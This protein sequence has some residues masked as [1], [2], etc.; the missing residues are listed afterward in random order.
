MARGKKI[1]LMAPAGNWESM[2]AAIDAGCDS[3]YFGIEQ[4]NMRA[5]QTMNFTLD[6][7]EEIVALCSPHDVRTYITLNTII[8]DH[9]LSLMRRIVDRAL[10]AGITAIIASD[11]AVISYASKVGLEVHISTQTN[12]TN[13]ETVEFFSHFADTMVLS[14]ELSMKQMKDL[15]DAVKRDNITGPNG[16][17]VEIEVFAHGALCVAVSGKCYM[18]LH[19]QAS[20]ANRGACIQNCRRSYTVKDTDSGYEFEIDDQYIMSPKDLCT[21]DFLDQLISTGVKVLKIEGRGRAPEYVKTVIECYREAID[22]VEAGTYN[23]ELVEAWMDRLKTVYNRG[24]WGGYYL[25][26]K[27]GEFSGGPGSKATQKKVFI[28]KGRH[29]YPKPQIGEFNVLSHGVKVGD[30]LLITGPTTGVIETEITSMM[31]DDKDAQEAKKGH[32]VTF[33]ISEKIRPSDKIYKIL[34]AEEVND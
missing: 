17:L 12:I 21:I 18:S 6:N 28:G 15:C 31:V 16:D 20:S 3:V 2:K 26:Q 19:T 30:K 7:L 27:L 5:R 4:L 25:G 13:I 22:A 8:Y 23:P 29:Y 34:P 10:E 14:R 11:Q 24:F 9:D 1:E 32:V 33:P